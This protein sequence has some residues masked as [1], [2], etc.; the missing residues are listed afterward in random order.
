[1][2]SISSIQNMTG[3]VKI[4]KK[5]IMKIIMQLMCTFEPLL[6]IF[7]RIKF[8]FRSVSARTKFKG[9]T[10]T[11]SSLIGSLPVV[12]VNCVVVVAECLNEL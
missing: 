2:T 7:K 6:R 11:S 8:I 9:L 5:S 3:I 10:A 4:M 12:I 1:M